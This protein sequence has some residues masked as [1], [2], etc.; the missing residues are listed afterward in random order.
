MATLAENLIT[1]SKAIGV[2][3][4]AMD[5]TKVGGKADATGNPL[6]VSHVAYKRALY[7]ELKDIADQ[8]ARIQGPVQVDS[9]GIV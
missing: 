5:S 2:E 7:A 4:A 1:R 6:H 3:L 9:Y 8:L